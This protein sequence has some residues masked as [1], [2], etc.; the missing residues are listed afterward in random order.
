MDI[1]DIS[2]IQALVSSST[3]LWTEHV[4][5]RLRE[6]GIKRSDVVT[7]LQNGEIIEQYPDDTPYPSCLVLG[8]VRQGVPLHVVCGVNNSV[9]CCIITA[10]YPVLDKWEND[11]KARKVAK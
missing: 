2:D 7:C 4:V 6:R 5:L 11:Y 3:I 10:Y 9:I 8:Y 1:I